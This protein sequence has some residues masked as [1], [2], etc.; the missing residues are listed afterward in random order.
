MP[1]GPWRLERF[2]AVHIDGWARCACLPSHRDPL[3]PNLSPS[4]GLCT[5]HTRFS[6]AHRELAMCGVDI[7]D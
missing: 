1:R 7:G 6:N 4:P 2:R 5:S 3:N